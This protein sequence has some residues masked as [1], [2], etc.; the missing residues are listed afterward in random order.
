M[1]H[2][3]VQAFSEQANEAI[4]RP[5]KF[6]SIRL[7]VMTALIFWLTTSAAIANSDTSL[8]AQRI[9][10]EN[11]ARP[12]ALDHASVE[13]TPEA[14]QSESRD[15]RPNPVSQETLSPRV[16]RPNLVALLAI[17]SSDNGSSIEKTPDE[18]LTDAIALGPR[19][20]SEPKNPF[21]KRTLDLFG[22]VH[23]VSIGNADLLVRFRVRGN[24]S[25]LMSFDVRF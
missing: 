8:V 19:P 18:S 15:V 6:S 23:P 12:T 5:A 16:R 21:R 3:A 7:L 2:R 22:T 14:A 25:E 24:M 13:G 9:G 1:R 20:E 10:P 4:A 11:S 17:R